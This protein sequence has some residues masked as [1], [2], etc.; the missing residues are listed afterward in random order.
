MEGQFGSAAMYRFLMIRFLNEI[1]RIPP[2][3][4]HPLAGDRKWGFVAV[5]PPVW[6]HGGLAV[7]SSQVTIRQRWFAPAGNAPQG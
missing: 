6:L 2:L 4:P 5:S 7:S 1:L 3:F